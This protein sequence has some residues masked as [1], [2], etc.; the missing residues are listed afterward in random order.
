MENKIYKMNSFW[1]KYSELIF[2][3][4]PRNICDFRGLFILSIL[5]SP[6]WILNK[7]FVQSFRSI[8]M[9]DEGGYGFWV[10]GTLTVLYIMFA[11]IMLMAGDVDILY[12]DGFSIFQVL[13]VLF[14]IGIL[15]SIGAC[16]VF[17]IAG[18]CVIMICTFFTE[19]FPQQIK[20][21]IKSHPNIITDSLK[22]W[23]DKVC[24]RIDWR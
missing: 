21:Q 15:L 14:L 5:T 18:V 11:L 1:G 10:D 24:Y 8:F 2:G 22:S 12:F 17:V 16:I 13:L 3:L 23:K 4:Y 19:W 7:V 6:L 9:P 20:T